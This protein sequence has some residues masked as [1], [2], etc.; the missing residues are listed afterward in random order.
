MLTA[1]EIERKRVWLDRQH[2]P[3]VRAKLDDVFTQARAAQG[4]Q[5]RIN[6]DALVIDQRNA[7][8]G[9]LQ[10]QVA[11][12]T[13][14]IDRLRQQNVAAMTAYSSIAQYVGLPSGTTPAECAVAVGRIVAD[15]AGPVPDLL[16]VEQAH[17]ADAYHCSCHAEESTE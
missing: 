9:T 17:V 6:S 3:A 14:E 8:I 4:L 5:D 15:L 11:D 7:M 16:V 10:V 1:E 13:A 2:G 12:Y